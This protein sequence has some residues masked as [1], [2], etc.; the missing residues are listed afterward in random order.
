VLAPA[1]LTLSSNWIAL[2]IG[3]S[4]FVFSLFGKFLLLFFRLPSCRHLLLAGC[5]GLNSDGPDR[6]RFARSAKDRQSSTIGVGVLFRHI[7]SFRPP[8]SA[9]IPYLA[10]PKNQL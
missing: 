5:F 9:P 4:V 10:V 3:L 1:A 8:S 7:Q 2:F 6:R